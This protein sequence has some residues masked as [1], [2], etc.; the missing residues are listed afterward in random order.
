MGWGKTFVK[1]FRAT[2]T[3]TILPTAGVSGIWECLRISIGDS[4]ESFH[5]KQ[6]WILPK[7]VLLVNSARFQCPRNS[8]RD[9]HKNSPKSSRIV[10]L[11]GNWPKHEILVGACN[12]RMAHPGGEGH[13][14]SYRWSMLEEPREGLF[15]ITKHLYLKPT[16]DCHCFS[17]KTV[18]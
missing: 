15:F 2:L 11:M 5:Q 14:V 8:A 17:K 16:V 13:F 1:D 7:K 10:S 9:T 18:I 6:S 3:F 4:S 12:V